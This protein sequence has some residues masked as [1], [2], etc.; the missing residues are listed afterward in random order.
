MSITQRETSSLKSQ[1]HAGACA[2]ASLSLSLTEF[3]LSKAAN[4]TRGFTVW[5]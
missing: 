3:T 4:Q 5:P 2:R 1:A